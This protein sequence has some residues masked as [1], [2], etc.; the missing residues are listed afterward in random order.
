MTLG[1]VWTLWSQ[2]ARQGLAKFMAMVNVV[3]QWQTLTTH[4][5]HIYESFDLDFGKGDNVPRI[6]NPVKFGWDCISGGAPTLW[7]NTGVACRVL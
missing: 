2:A 5:S 1:I 3:P 7:W 6:N 4:Q